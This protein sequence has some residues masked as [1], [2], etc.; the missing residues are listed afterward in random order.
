[1]PRV[2][3][4][5]LS[6]ES[7]LLTGELMSLTE[8]LSEL[9]LS[10]ED[11]G[12]RRMGAQ[13]DR[14]FSPAGRVLL[15]RLCRYMFL[16]NPLINRAVMVQTY[17][18][19]GQGV[20]IQARYPEVNQV[21]QAFLSDRAN[22]TELTSHQARTLKEVDLS[23]LGNLFFVF[24]VTPS[25]G[26]VRIRTIPVEE[27]TDIV[28]DPE[29]ART[30]WFYR[31]TW[32]QQSMDVTTGAYVT[33]SRT[34][35]YPDWRYN[36][37]SKPDSIGGYPVYWDTPAYHV[38]VGGLSDMQFGVSEIYQGIDWARAYTEFLENRA[39]VAKALARFA[40]RTTVPGGKGGIAAAKTKLGT[41]I[42]GTGIETNPPPV[43]GSA[44]IGGINGATL[45]PIRVAGATINPEEGRRFLLMVCAAVGLPETF[46]G[47][48]SA[49]SLATARSLDRPTQLKFADRQ[50]LWRDVFRDILEYV[51]AWSV[52]AP[53]GP[54][55]MLGHVAEDGDTERVSWQNDPETGEPINATVDV[56]FPDIL[57]ADK[58]ANITAIVQAATLAGHP[59]VGTLDDRTTSRL[60]LT[61]LGVD[62]VDE[63]L[64]QIAPADGESLAAQM[65]NQ[66]AA[67]AQAIAD[68]QAAG[69][70]NQASG[71]PVDQQ[72]TP[73]QTATEALMVRAIEE[74]REAISKGIEG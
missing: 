5:A 55:R 28:A 47:D 59:A 72:S 29:D 8:R 56:A 70:Q 68:K 44:W 13:L 40:W 9:E 74:L 46:F 54:L 6:E 30:P 34:A 41:T 45:D 53:S 52:K 3:V 18:V 43:A 50:S 42:N 11:A 73:D 24:F 38:K 57:E 15:L 37:P 62:N 32:S 12:W 39:T 51:V 4:K 67:Q 22:Q 61:N 66:K 17:Y 21:V 20:N 48:A 10:M 65:Q 26:K 64:D 60:L 19:W 58:V 71:Q 2:T 63:L 1:M 25:T 23:T 49:G 27:V 16:K 7:Q 35:F 31:R 14:E 36:P 33:E 69:Q